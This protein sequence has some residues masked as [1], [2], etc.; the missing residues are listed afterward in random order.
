MDDFDPDAYLAAK[1]G[2]GTAVAEPAA[3]D[4]DTYLQSKKVE[5]SA[6]RTPA[7]ESGLAQLLET[8]EG[9]PGYNDA[10]TRPDVGA[11]LDYLRP[12][13]SEPAG[14][15]LGA[16]PRVAPQTSVA[17]QIAGGV[18]N[19]AANVAESLTSPQN[20]VLL[21][22]AGV[23]GVGRLAGLLFGAEALGDVPSAARETIAPDRT[24]QQRIESGGRTLTD[25]LFGAAGVGHGSGLT[26][27]LF[28][29]KDSTTPAVPE[30]PP[31]AI[32][33]PI[34]GGDPIAPSKET[35]IAAQAATEVPNEPRIIPTPEGTNGA[36]APAGETLGA[37]D[38]PS[39]SIAE[40]SVVSEPESPAVDAAIPREPPVVEAVA[41]TEMATAAETVS[42][43][44]EE[45]V[46]E[47][48]GRVAQSEQ[49]VATPESDP[50][51]TAEQS[52]PP[53]GGE[54]M[55]PGPG[56]A[57]AQEPL[58]SY[59]QRRFGKRFQA[60]ESIAPEIREQ[61]GNQY[62]EP[63]PNNVTVSDAE[64]IIEQ[65]GTDASLRLVRDDNAPLPPRV[66]V[67]MGQALIKKLNQSHQEA[68]A[69]G[70]TARAGEFLNQAVDTAEHLSDL[71]TQ[72]GQGVQAFSIWNKLNPDGILTAAIRVAKKAGTDLTPEQI[73]QVSDISA[74]IEKAPEGF[75]RNEKTMKLMNF[76]A[77][78]KGANPADIPTA[79][80]YA[81]ILSGYSTQ[82]VNTIDTGINVLSESAAMAASHPSAIPDILTGL[83]QGMVR[84]G[85]E[86]ANVLKTGKAT[87][88]DKI[89]Q[90]QILERTQFGK[91]GG[92][93]INTDTAL[94]RFMKRAFESKPA[95]PLNLWKYPL[96]A[97]LASDTVFYNSMKEARARVLARA[98]A[99]K[100]GLSGDALF[101]RTDEVLNQ[102]PG[103]LD[104]ALQQA[105]SEGLTGLN[106][107]RRT[108]E[109]IEQGRD[110]ALIDNAG[111]A[112]EIATYN[113][114]PSGVLGLV[115]HH[116]SQITQN[117]PMAKA[118]V[119][120]TRIV[121]NVS[122]R[123]L[124]YT[125]YGYKRLF[126]GHSGGEKF[127][128]AP[129]VGEAYRTQLVKATLGTAAMTA[130][131]ALDAKGTIQISAQGPS[132]P[133]ERKQLSNTGWKP[134]S[135]KV[136]DT[137]YS[138]QYT[139]LNI[140]FAMIGHY[141]DAVR[142]N[143]L[144]EKDAQTRLAYGML[145][146]STTIMD[147]SFLSG[148][149]DFMG[150]VSGATSSTKGVGN[151]MARTASSV[152]IPNLAK[153]IDKL[154]DPT[155]YQADTVKEALMRETPIARSATL[156]PMLNMLGDPIKPSQ[157]R[158]FTSQTDDPVWKLIVA[159][160]AWIPVPSKTTKIKNRA[161][162][163]DEYYTLIEKSGPQIRRFIQRNAT[164][165]ENMN[166]EKVQDEIRDETERVRKQI[167]SRF[168]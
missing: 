32:T 153:Q 28:R 23:R 159:K 134:Y 30:T 76:M 70:D 105:Q 21:P 9:S 40:S 58:A 115:A 48:N 60:D 128:T 124:D 51:T 125:P 53:T 47:T 33:E 19:V 27:A 98:L 156:K 79:I 74:E 17:G 143:K 87:M 50:S 145:K 151:L 2:G 127:G 34:A 131:A 142:Y 160:Q 77:D 138:Y 129:P 4:P 20:L 146:S 161:I 62:Y 109:I 73:K 86:A 112:A 84:G 102:G 57:S 18:A 157:N 82:L 68:V 5:P 148:L 96:R 26:D 6:P 15:V 37:R 130:A 63:V 106:L 158:F 111:E 36:E 29:P 93:P 31:P 166:G 25:V 52:Q 101:Q 103:K 35:Q 119:P 66:R 54:I 45:S 154:F 123:G 13:P 24:L 3:F 12:A 168:D 104:A 163:P 56:A 137:Y 150:T 64:N 107:R 44:V 89:G 139:P 59:E 71:G 141:R 118:V 164:R 100:E 162:T 94:G 95:A 42:A 114:D 90:Q 92:V 122:N 165:F 147:M 152:V 121:A 43:P 132:D 97:M 88:A 140:G 39:A 144:D 1:S 41:P 14:S 83:Y 72:L 116:I 126:F 149:S 99:K 135:V 136:G 67:T 49:S 16:I 78:M 75:Q 81:N 110:D 117:F 69:A 155:V 7:V 108:R 10:V 22:S 80:Y 38:E 61:T 8:P 120:F 167:K 133:N 91:E 85:F 55:S 46:P 11:A 65:H 113:H